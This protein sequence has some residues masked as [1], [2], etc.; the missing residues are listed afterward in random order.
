MHTTFKSEGRYVDATFD[1][2]TKDGLLHIVQRNVE[3]ETGRTY[4]VGRVALDADEFF[5]IYGAL[6]GDHKAAFDTAASYAIFL[7]NGYGKISVQTA[8]ELWRVA[9]HQVNNFLVLR[10]N[11]GE[12]FRVL[13][14]EDS[15]ELLRLKEN[16][17]DNVTAYCHRGKVH[18]YDHQ[19][20]E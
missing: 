11:E 12:S 16:F 18:I 1:A 20:T 9:T 13:A 7:L 15:V 19:N 3:K 14:L 2:F 6:V 5:A 4:E 17:G 10:G 8:R